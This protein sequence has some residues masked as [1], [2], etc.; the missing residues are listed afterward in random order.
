[1]RVFATGSRFVEGHQHA[2]A[3]HAIALL[4]ACLKRPSNRR[5]SEERDDLAPSKAN[6]HLRL[7]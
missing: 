4:R 5:A 6:R 1:M 7:H 3:P 2:D